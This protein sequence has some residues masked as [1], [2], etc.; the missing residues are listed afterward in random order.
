MLKLSNGRFT[1]SE[2]RLVLLAP[3][4]SVPNTFQN[5]ETD[6]R[7]HGQFVREMQALRGRVYLQDGAIGRDQLSADGLHETAEDE[8]SWHLLT[9]DKDR[10]VSGCAWYLEHES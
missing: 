8:R 1:L 4:S 6:S 5:V 2:N 7:Q 10:R 9:L 3:H